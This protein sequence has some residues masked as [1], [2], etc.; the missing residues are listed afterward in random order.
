[1]KGEERMYLL[2]VGGGK[3]GFALARDLIQSGHEVTLIEKQPERAQWL[4]RLLGGAVLCGDGTNPETL[5]EGGIERADVVIA[6]SGH[7]EDNYAISRIAT[8]FKTGTHVIA[9]VNDPRNEEIFRRIGVRTVSS[10]RTIAEMIE[11]SVPHP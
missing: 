1:M 9:R 8:A 3:V 7:D 4:A 11:E 6:V 5:R 2:V 10:T